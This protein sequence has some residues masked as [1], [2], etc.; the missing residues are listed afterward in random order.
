MFDS[1]GLFSFL[2]FEEH[3]RP[4][5]ADSG[6][7]YCYEEFEESEEYE[8][9]EEDEEEDDENEDDSNDDDDDE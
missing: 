4:K 9:F 8:E 1:T 3:T 2:L 5:K 6:D 7:R